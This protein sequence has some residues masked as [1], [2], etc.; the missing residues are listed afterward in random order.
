VTKLQKDQSDL[1]RRLRA[2]RATRGLSLAQLAKRTG[3]SSSF[4]SLV[5]QGKSDIT[6]TRLL[7]LSQFYQV[8][9]GDLIAE[10]GVHG[11][12]PIVVHR[13]SAAAI[14]SAGEGI[15]VYFLLTGLEHP[16]SATIGAYEPAATLTNEPGFDRETFA[17]VLNGKLS[18][19]TPGA[20]ALTVSA[21]DAVIYHLGRAYTWTN[22]SRRR[23]H[24][25]F[26]TAQIGWRGPSHARN[27]RSSA[28]D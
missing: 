9:L 3:I 5:E 2:F 25:L 7:R 28:T 19:A 26:V 20:S 21:G 16:F 10:D 4:I 14:H 11:R 23:A 6:I 13:R 22:I 17:Y 24:V 1:G 15:N 27:R 12:E 18:I 8:G